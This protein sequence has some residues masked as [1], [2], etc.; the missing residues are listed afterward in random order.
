[1]NNDID[2]KRG[3]TDTLS[4]KNKRAIRYSM[5]INDNKETY[6]AVLLHSK[7]DPIKKDT[8]ISKNIIE[9][10]EK[11]HHNESKGLQDDMHILPV[12]NVPK[13]TPREKVAEQKI[14][15][16]YNNINNDKTKELNY[17]LDTIRNMRK[18]NKHQILYLDTLK[19]NELKS[20]ILEYNKV[21]DIIEYLL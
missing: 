2:K 1:M 15:E 20:I 4:D 12:L 14:P 21:I 6:K 17:L 9:K 8:N 3:L 13:N 19:I 10:L 7:S 16:F 18:L 11:I 5:A